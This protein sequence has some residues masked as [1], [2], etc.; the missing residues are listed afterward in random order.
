VTY[1]F[2]TALAGIKGLDYTRSISRNGF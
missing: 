2:E 1:P